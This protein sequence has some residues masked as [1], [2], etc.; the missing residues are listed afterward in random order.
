VKETEKEKKSGTFTC[1]TFFL[2]STRSSSFY[3][4]NDLRG[5]VIDLPFDSTAGKKYITLQHGC[6]EGMYV[7]IHSFTTNDL[8][9]LILSSLYNLSL[10]SHIIST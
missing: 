9:F 4:A 3:K 1:M 6:L 8:F 10:I 7:C 5:W 2:P